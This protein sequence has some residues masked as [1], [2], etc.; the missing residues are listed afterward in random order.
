MSTRSGRRYRSWE[1]FIL[2]RV[3]GCLPFLDEF[4]GQTDN[5]TSG[6]PGFEIIRKKFLPAD[7]GIH[8]WGR[9]R[10]ARKSGPLE[11]LDA[12]I[13]VVVGHSA[14]GVHHAFANDVVPLRPMDLQIPM[15]DRRAVHATFIPSQCIH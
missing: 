6:G 7:I 4:H 10:N 15:G 1:D 5:W 9:Y 13:G 8:A 12:Y 14:V 2:Y 11:F 3:I